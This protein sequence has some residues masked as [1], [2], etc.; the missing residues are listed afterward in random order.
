MDLLT[1]LLLAAGAVLTGFL[2]SNLARGADVSGNFT[3]PK[4]GATTNYVNGLA[5][6]FGTRPVDSFDF[7]L[8]LIL[9]GALIL[10]FMA[11]MVLLLNAIK[12]RGQI[13]ELGMRVDN[14]DYSAEKVAD[15]ALRTQEDTL[16]NFEKN[17]I[18]LNDTVLRLTEGLNQERIAEAFAKNITATNK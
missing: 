2:G 8:G 11:G 12:H 4:G 3:P 10:L 16:K 7:I 15:S 13:T 6:N 18:A 5:Q 17:V 14:R 9:L 1:A